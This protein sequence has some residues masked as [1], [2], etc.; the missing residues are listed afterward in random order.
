M[1][2]NKPLILVTNDDGIH[3]K[4]LN[5]L[6]D[7]AKP[8]GNLFVIAPEKG[9]SGMSHAITINTPVRIKQVMESEGI[10]VYSCSGT[11]VD[12]VKLAINRLLPRKPDYLLSGINHGSN[13]SISVIYSGTLGAAIEGCLNGIPSA[14]FSILDHSDN[15]DFSAP[16]KYCAKIISNI[17]QNGLELNTCLNVNFPAVT[18][19]KIKGIKVCRQAKGV[20]K[21][22]YDKRTDPHNKEYFWL[23]GDFHNF[24][25]DAADTDEWSLKNNFISIVPIKV[26]FTSYDTMKHLYA[27]N[28]EITH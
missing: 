2:N 18:S 14:G 1:N 21:E 6:I 8:F 20:W 9:E 17:L 11:P 12:S 25:P 7:I 16:Q 19:E 15:P 23:T 3:A 13:S 22:E 26:D 4:G 27:W 10:S 5:T 24:E 28:Y